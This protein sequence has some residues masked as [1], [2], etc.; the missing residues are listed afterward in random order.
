[1]EVEGAEHRGMGVEGTELSGME[2][3]G[4]ELEVESTELRG[5][6]K[7][8]ETSKNLEGVELMGAKLKS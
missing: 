4:A 8:C 1:M 3:E 7:V 5:R 6:G 2:V